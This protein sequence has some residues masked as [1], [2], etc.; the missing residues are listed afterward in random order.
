MSW[1]GLEKFNG[2]KMNSKIGGCIAGLKR[3]LAMMHYDHLRSYP[4]T[5]G[6]IS[7]ILY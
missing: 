7:F 6:L 1:L 2:T 3:R 5:C 4:M